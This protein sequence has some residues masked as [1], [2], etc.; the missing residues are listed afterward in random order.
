MDN[1]SLM[2]SYVKAVVKIKNL[3]KGYPSFCLKHSSSLS[4]YW[5]C[6]EG[7]LMVLGSCVKLMKELLEPME[8]EAACFAEGASLFKLASILEVPYCIIA[9][10]C[11]YVMSRTL[12]IPVPIPRHAEK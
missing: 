8:A 4:E 3:L 1:P 7:Y 10:K 6:P 12:P 11:A 9:V 2:A 5:Q